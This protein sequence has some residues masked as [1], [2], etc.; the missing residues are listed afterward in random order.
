[1]LFGFL[2]ISGNWGKGPDYLTFVFLLGR[3]SRFLFCSSVFGGNN[4]VGCK[5]YHDSLGGWMDGDDVMR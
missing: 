1:V 2:M 3:L 5:I 4:C